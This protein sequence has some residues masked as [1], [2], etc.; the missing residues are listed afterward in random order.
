MLYSDASAVDT[1]PE[2]DL[3]S[4]LPEENPKANDEAPLENDGL[5]VDD[6]NTSVNA[7]A[8]DVEVI[9]SESIQEDAPKKSYASIVSFNLSC[10]L[11]IH[12]FSVSNIS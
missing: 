10:Y 8:P 6:V 2:S 5:V 9:T 1:K 4:L 7:A 12:I 3:S 11:K